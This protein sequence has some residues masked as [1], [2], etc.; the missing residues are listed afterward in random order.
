[1]SLSAE[2]HPDAVVPTTTIDEARI[3]PMVKPKRGRKPKATPP[4]TVPDAMPAALPADATHNQVLADARAEIELEQALHALVEGTVLKIL[5]DGEDYGISHA[6]NC[7]EMAKPAPFQGPGRCPSCR[8]KPELWLPGAEKCAKRLGYTY[9]LPEVADDIMR[10]THIEAPWIAFRVALIRKRDGEVVGH[11]IGGRTLAQSN[12]DPN[13]MMKMGKKS[14]IIDCAKT[15]F[16]LS[17]FFSQDSDVVDKDDPLRATDGTPG[18]S[19][20]AEAAAVVPANTFTPAMPPAPAPVT[21]AGA[22]TPVA[23]PT[24]ESVSAD[25]ARIAEACGMLPEDKQRLYRMAGWVE[26]E[27]ITDA[28]QHELRQRVLALLRGPFRAHV[29]AAGGWADGIAPS[30]ART[31]YLLPWLAVADPPKAQATLQIP[32]TPM[33]GTPVIP[34][35]ATPSL[36]RFVAFYAIDGDTLQ[37]LYSCAGWKAGAPPTETHAR[38]AYE[39]CE[40]ALSN[41]IQA[42]GGWP[43]EGAQ[44]SAEERRR[45]VFE[46]WLQGLEDFYSKNPN[47]RPTGA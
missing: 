23:P 26:G 33:P 35:R 8:R 14:A 32:A 18:G 11:G 7:T 37:R 1:M 12:G 39:L 9:G 27:V 43:A 44:W 34:D 38:V 31:Q 13:T 16:A 3:L 45:H 6:R 10:A 2:S 21:V 29:D 47:Q 42:H 30:A 5:Q 36:D 4:A 20:P 22:A 24:P 17:G 40:Q 41:W 19:T 25:L 15:N 28:R 46:P